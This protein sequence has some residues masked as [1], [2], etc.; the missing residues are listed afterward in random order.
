MIR[1]DLSD[2]STRRINPPYD[3]GTPW[4]S[5][6]PRRCCR[7]TPVRH[8]KVA[9]S[10]CSLLRPDILGA[11]P[12]HSDGSVKPH[13]PHT[14]TKPKA[15]PPTGG[16]A[17]IRPPPTPAQTTAVSVGSSIGRVAMPVALWMLLQTSAAA[18]PTPTAVPLPAPTPVPSA[19]CYRQIADSADG[20]S[21]CNDAR[22]LRTTASPS[23]PRCS[24][25]TCRSS[26]AA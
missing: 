15:A 11:E 16:D 22:A 20:D 21:V 7:G 12:D 19:E 17:R 26:S 6:L 5:H 9:K 8:D 2:P 3:G 14:L 25:I 24:Y 4:P 1:S 10:S 23:G 13:T 18:S